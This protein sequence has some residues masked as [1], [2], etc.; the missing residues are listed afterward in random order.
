MTGPPS[1]SGSYALKSKVSLGLFLLPSRLDKLGH[2]SIEH[3]MEYLLYTKLW[4]KPNQAIHLEA[5]AMGLRSMNSSRWVLQPQHAKRAGGGGCSPTLSAGR[6]FRQGGQ[7]SFIPSKD[8]WSC[9]VGPE[10]SSISLNH[11]Y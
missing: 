11:Y 6:R 8:G 1:Q 7:E 5:H 3:I 10:E 4:A 2:Y 9:P